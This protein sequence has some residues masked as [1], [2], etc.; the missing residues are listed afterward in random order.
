VDSDSSVSRNQA[1]NMISVYGDVVLIEYEEDIDTIAN[2]AYPSLLTPTN[3]QTNLPFSSDGNYDKV[4]V[5]EEE[6]T[7]T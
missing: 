3:I 6:P 5:I 1:Y 2:S 7:M 4:S